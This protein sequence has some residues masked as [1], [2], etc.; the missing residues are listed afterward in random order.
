M[1]PVDGDWAEQVIPNSVSVGLSNMSPMLL[2]QYEIEMEIGNVPNFQTMWDQ[3]F[4]VP[5]V[6]V[7]SSTGPT[8]EYERVIAWRN[9]K[10]HLRR[11]DLEMLTDRF[12]ALGIV[13]RK[14]LRSCD[15]T[16][17]W[18]FE[19]YEVEHGMCSSSRGEASEPTVTGLGY[20]FSINR[21][22]FDLL[23]EARKNETRS[24]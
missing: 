22:A 1:Y 23:E 24:P 10:Y 11:S 18:D 21:S 13:R 4:E 9:V 6:E 16:P 14:N 15:E 2:F 7:V 20:C 12:S 17:W 3:L 5:F 19:D 8:R